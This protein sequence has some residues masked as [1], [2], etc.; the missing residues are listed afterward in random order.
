MDAD[1]GGD[2]GAESIARLRRPGG[3]LRFEDHGHRGSRRDDHRTGRSRGG[4][5]LE[6]VPGDNKQ[7]LTKYRARNHDIYIGRWGPDYQDPHT[8]ADTFAS[9]PDNSDAAGLTGKL[10]WRNAWDIPE[11]TAETAAAVLER[12]A[13]KR[14][15]MYRELQRKVMETG[16]FVIMFQ[17]IELI[18]E[19]NNVADMIWGPSFD[20]N[21][22]A[23]GRKG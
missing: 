16:P 1:G 7:T 9:N 4:V 22:Y 19:R 17:D 13:G 2:P 23:K 11:I 3:Q 21:S 20:S 6:I 18:A 15:E 8:N 12:D 10:A 14:A 5:A